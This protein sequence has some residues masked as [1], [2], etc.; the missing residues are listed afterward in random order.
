MECKKD[1]NKG[2]CTCTYDCPRRGLCCECVKY[3]LAKRQVP[4]CFFSKAGEASYDRS[5][6]HFAKEVLEKKI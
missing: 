2:H 5:F 4:G 1:E 6:E 3:H